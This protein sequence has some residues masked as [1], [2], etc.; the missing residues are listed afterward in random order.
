MILVTGAKG[1]IGS[2]LC[3]ELSRS[4]Y[5]VA[6]A[7]LP[8]LDI[9]QET[10]FD[11]LASKKYERIYHIAGKTFIP[12][13]WVNP[14]DFYKTNTFGTL[15]VLEY[16]RKTGTPLTFI[17]AY[18]YGQPERN[19]IKETDPLKPNNPYSHSKYIAE[20]LC[21]SY[22]ENFGF[23]VAVVRPFNVYGP[24][25]KPQF[26]IPLLI[27]QGVNSK[28][29][30]VKTLTPRRDYVH[31][32]DLI[33]ALMLTLKI[34]KG[35]HVYNIGSGKSQSVREI[36]RY[37]SKLCGNKRIISE[38]S[39]RRDE[40]PDTVA[41]IHL[42]ERELGWKPQIEFRTA[43]KHM[44]QEMKEHMPINKGNYS[45]E[46]RD[47]EAAFEKCRGSGWEAAYNRYRANWSG[48]PK[49]HFVS[50]YPLLLDIELSSV[51]NLRCPMCYTI[52]E[53]F[54]RKVNASLMSFSLFKRIID[55]IGGKVPA[56]RLSLRGE[57]TLHPNFIKCVEYA[58][59]KN[60]NEVSL[61]TNA[62]TLTIGNFKKMSDAGVDWITVSIDGLGKTYE[63]IRKPLKFAETLRKIKEIH[64]Y[65]TDHK[66]LRPV[67]KVQSVWPAIK[68]N[69]EKYYNTFA[70]YTDFV[71]FNPLIDYLGKDSNIVAEDNFVCPQQYQRLVIGADGLAMM[72]SNDEEGAVIV[73]NAN[74]QRIFSI[75]HGAKL[76][77]VRK[78]H[79]KRNGFLKIPVC[80]KC[81]LPRKTEDSET[82]S[83]NG[84]RFIVRNYVNRLQ[85]IGG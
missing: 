15:N 64:K 60:I 4:G 10:A 19:P 41:D 12:D 20:E 38:N 83:V 30:R 5:Q 57:P 39:R 81:Y 34:N 82:A 33:R 85:K 6:E 48:Y 9:V 23:S 21:R 74:N 76:S 7:D 63:S 14:L 69:P 35:F 80:R 77:S 11:G 8:G 36:V 68:Q 56:I 25:Q 66:L 49:A 16:C 18:V 78:Q 71:A 45:M 84:R 29:I 50:P 54:R 28:E 55:E 44:V 72:C 52:T 3:A 26:L 42:A 62:S 22:S 31:L 13:S 53:E 73:G 75:W 2:A 67:I 70:P 46:T 17:S 79:L 27:N 40:I 43:I 51:C 61:L 24:G 47:R 32:S 65:K 37:I 58:K 59:K 1:F